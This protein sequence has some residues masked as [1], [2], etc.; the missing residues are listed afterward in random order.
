MFLMFLQFRVPR[1]FQSRRGT[2]RFPH[3][4][5]TTRACACLV[6]GGGGLNVGWVNPRPP[7][8]IPNR[9]SV[10]RP[11]SGLAWR[12]LVSGDCRFWRWSWS[13]A[14]AVALGFGALHGMAAD[15]KLAALTARKDLT[16]ES[17]LRSF[18][19]FGFELG[20]RAQD[21]ETFL[22]RQRGDCD[23]FARL[24]ARLLSGGGYRT[25]LVLVMM[26]GQTHLVCY[27]QEAQGFLDFNHRA[28]PHPVVPSDGSLEDIALKVSADFRSPWWMASEVGFATEGAGAEPVY[29]D[30]VFPIEAAPTPAR[31]RQVATAPAKPA[32]AGGGATAGVEADAPTAGKTSTAVLA[33]ATLQP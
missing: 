24:A 5:R 21:G 8:R 7:R 30:S 31:G 15:G 1:P 4:V 9:S 23:D 17:L 11:R 29:L 14:S 12:R 27:V 3:L 32:L 19:G 13:L 16:P 28:D 2:T 25:R 33:D 18:A 20:E 6:Q 10:P 26:P 22:E